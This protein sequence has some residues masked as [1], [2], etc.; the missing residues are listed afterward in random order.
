M[1]PFPDLFDQ[2]L[3]I[4]QGTV[5]DEITLTMGRV[6]TAP[7]I[8]QEIC[9]FNRRKSVKKRSSSEL[10]SN[11]DPRCPGVPLAHCSPSSGYRRPPQQLDDF[12]PEDADDTGPQA[13]QQVGGSE[14]REAKKLA[15]KWN[16]EDER[17]EQQTT[18]HHPPEGRITRTQH[19][20]DQARL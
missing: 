4:M 12:E 11:F 2:D 18:S 3:Q 15:Q 8:S 5:A 7:T 20:Q 17:E 1:T 10:R 14:Q 9:S 16:G 6:G 13:D 19:G